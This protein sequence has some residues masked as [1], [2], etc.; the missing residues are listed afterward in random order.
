LMGRSSSWLGPFNSW[1]LSHNRHS[2]WCR[3]WITP[4]VNMIWSNSVEENSI[5]GILNEMIFE[6]VW[7]KSC[8]WYQWNQ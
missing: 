2:Q 5:D 4:M 6:N 8:A 1:I 7:Q 3:S